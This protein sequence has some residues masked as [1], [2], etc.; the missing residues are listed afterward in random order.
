[1]AGPT[2]VSAL[3]HAATMVKA[4]VYLVARVSP[5]FYIGTWVL[6]IPEAQ[7]YFIAIAL[8]GA[9]TTFLA[10]SQALVSVE[11]KK[12]LA[13]STVSQIGYMM[14]GLGLSGFSEEAYLLGLTSGI[15]HL[16]SHALFK[17]AL[18]L[19][20]GSVIHAV[21]S[22]Y[23]FNMGGLKKH[24]PKTY[25]LMLL[26]TLSLS[27]IPPFSG[28]W[29]KD[30][31]FLSAITAG[32]PLAMLLLLVGVISAAMTFAYSL[33]YISKTFLHEESEFLNELEDH[34]H[35]LHEAPSVM[36][37]PIAVLVV[38]FS[39]IGLLGL[40][41][42]ASPSL[43]PEVFIEEQLHHTIEHILPH[44]IAEHLHVPHVSGST[45]LVGA[46]LSGIA[47]AVG[48][49]LGWQFY[50]KRN[51]DSWAW[52]QASNLRKSVYDF[53]WNRWYMNIAY[54]F[55]FVDG[56]VIVSKGINQIFEQRVMTPLSD[57]L[58][59]V[60]VSLSQVMY[61]VIEVGGIF[62]VVNRRIPA[63]FQNAYD[64]VKKIQTGVLEMN[65]VYIFLMLFLILLA[66]F[67]IGG[68]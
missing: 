54:Y 10:A 22:I 21:E 25:I 60:S 55:V 39:V 24:M 41:G 61:N 37:G 67:Y 32:T 4:G 49:V 16:A 47:L 64:R 66:M 44:D 36:W 19:S 35:H 15:F 56:L 46:G 63:T 62:G 30:A 58:A 52:V 13:Y 51:W 17:A 3:I 27:G 29:S 53:L 65:L 59:R 33:R 40:V 48:G 12:I 38:L 20:A 7:I 26:A 50:W 2:P 6:H 8:V 5:I 34:G 9:F 28:F 45:K 18:F 42:L 43:S 31:V 14:L 57:Y 23:I 1:M 68:L 11:L